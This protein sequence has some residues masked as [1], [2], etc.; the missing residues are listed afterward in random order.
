MDDEHGVREAMSLRRILAEP[1]FSRAGGAPLVPGNAVRLLRDAAE[2]YPAW[3][4]AI[5]A[6]ADRSIRFES[7]IIHEGAQDSSLPSCWRPRHATAGASVS[8]M[9]GSASLGHASRRFW[10]ALSQAGVEVRCFNPPR[11]DSPFGWL[12]RDHRKVIV[13]DGRVGFAKGLCV[14]QRWVGDPARGIEP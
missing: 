4:E 5:S 2:N 11:F 10:R 12:S 8:S 1:A 3:L 6:A 13:V 7:Y 14:G 9:T